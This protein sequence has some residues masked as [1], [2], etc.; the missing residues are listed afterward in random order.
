M[1]VVSKLLQPL[2][3]QCTKQDTAPVLIGTNL[4]KPAKVGGQTPD[5]AQ[6]QMKI[7]TNKQFGLLKSNF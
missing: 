5:V 6:F 3:E 7:R 2:R 1:R 4:I